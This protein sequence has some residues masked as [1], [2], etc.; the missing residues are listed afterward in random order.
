MSEQEVAQSEW[1]EPSLLE[2]PEA[3]TSVVDLIS[4]RAPRL[5]AVSLVGFRSV[6]ALLTKLRF[7]LIAAEPDSAESVVNLGG[8]P[9]AWGVPTLIGVRHESWRD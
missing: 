7:G 8:T 6:Q 2:V 9:R 5:L 1:I 3:V 4:L